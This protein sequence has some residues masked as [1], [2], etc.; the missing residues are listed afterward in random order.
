MQVVSIFKS[1]P[2]TGEL[3]YYKKSKLTTENVN[4]MPYTWNEVL[5]MGKGGP[6][7]ESVIIS[8]QT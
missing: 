4:K 2:D 7:S 5:T 6:P 1:T 8:E 3:T